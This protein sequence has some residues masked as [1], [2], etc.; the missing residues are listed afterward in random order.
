MWREGG[1]AHGCV[2][3]CAAPSLR[4]SR[5]SATSRTVAPQAPLSVGFS[6]QEHWC[7]VPFPSPGDLPNPGIEPK[8]PVSP[9][10]QADSLPP[11]PF[12]LLVKMKIGTFTET[13]WWFLKRLKMG[14]PH[15]PAVSPV[16]GILQARTLV[17]VAISFSTD[18]TKSTANL[19]TS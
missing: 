11:E 6:Q 12:A 19:S 2:C 3:T 13:A 5:L 17:W 1:L 18:N 9:A 7:G 15:S 16:P 8:S 10:L 14:L 4:C